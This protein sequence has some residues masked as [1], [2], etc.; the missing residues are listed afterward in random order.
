MAYTSVNSLAL[1]ACTNHPLDA[2]PLFIGRLSTSWGVAL[3]LVPVSAGGCGQPAAQPGTP[4]QQAERADGAST[5][6]HL[7]PRAL[8]MA[9][10][11]GAGA[12]SGGQPAVVSWPR[13]AR[14][15]RSRSA[16]AAITVGGYTVYVPLPFVERT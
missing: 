9:Q 8:A 16:L 14:M 11:P 2:E 3:E 4:G 5:T 6:L 10:G 7:P 13:G 12:G 15:A 1:D